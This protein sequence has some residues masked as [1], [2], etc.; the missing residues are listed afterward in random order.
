MQ[1][2]PPHSKCRQDIQKQTAI[3][4]GV[5]ILD[6][7]AARKHWVA[8]LMRFDGVQESLRGSSHQ[9][10]P[11]LPSQVYHRSLS[12]CPAGKS[13][14]PPRAISH[15]SSRTNRPRP[16][17]K[18]SI[19]GFY[20]G[21]LRPQRDSKTGQQAYLMRHRGVLMGVRQ[22]QPPRGLPHHL[23]SFRPDLFN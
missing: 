3:G 16:R 12:R 22:R 9:L 23:A 4:S 2:P 5:C 8:S 14:Q 18:I 19:G 15:G 7:V 17:W 1:P 20:A 10:A 6:V 13:E 11:R 21:I